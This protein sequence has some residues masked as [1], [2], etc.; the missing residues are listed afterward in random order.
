MHMKIP[1]SEYVLIE[2]AGHLTNIENPSRFNEVVMDFLLRH[3]DG[4]C[5]AQLEL[6]CSD[7]F[8]WDGVT[9]SGAPLRVTRLRLSDSELTGQFPAELGS[10]TKLERS[11]PQR[12]PVDRR[13]PG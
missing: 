12:Q 13:D 5:G 1:G 3:R 4:R 11:G 8:D 7:Q 9:I 2:D 6:R 10:L